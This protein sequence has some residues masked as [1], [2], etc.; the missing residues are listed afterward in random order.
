MMQCY[1]PLASRRR[2]MFASDISQG[3]SARL[4]QR[5]VLF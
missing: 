4:V 3:K 2:A 5:G 1:I